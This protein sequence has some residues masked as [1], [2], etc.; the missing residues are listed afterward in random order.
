MGDVVLLIGLDDQLGQELRRA[1]GGDRRTVHAYP[2]LPADGGRTL[3]EHLHP[4]L[5]FLGGDWHAVRELLRKIPAPVVVVSRNPEV[6][7]W[8]DA[9]EAGATDYCAPPFETA[10]LAWIVE[11]A[12]KASRAAA[13]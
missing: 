4:S 1:I 3:I 8:L 13:A 6:S 7:D 9:I 10:H 12:G 5:I 11:S 2:S